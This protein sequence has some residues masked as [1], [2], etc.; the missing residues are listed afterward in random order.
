MEAIKEIITKV[1]S[2]NLFNYLLPGVLFVLICKIGIEIDLIV[3]NNIL[4][5]FFYYFIGMTISRIGSIFLEPFLKWTKFLKFKE[6]KE[7]VKAS[8]LDTKI[9][10]LSEVNNTYRTIFTM[11]LLLTCIKIF[12]YFNSTYWHISHSYS[13]SAVLVIILILFLYSYRKQT[14]YITKRIDSNL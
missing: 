5:A 8:K 2:Y 7:F 12:K 3:E 11:L 6:Y 14:N 10:V 1:S 13:Y 4:G 9:E